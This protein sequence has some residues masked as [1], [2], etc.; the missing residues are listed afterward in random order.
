LKT[1]LFDV[2]GKL[3]NFECNIKEED[4]V[5]AVFRFIGEKYDGIDLLVRCDWDRLVGE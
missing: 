1:S 5:K 4:Q 2:K 3:I